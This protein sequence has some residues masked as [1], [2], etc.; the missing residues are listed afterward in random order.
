MSMIKYVDM[1]APPLLG[2][3]FRV[4]GKLDPVWINV[5]ENNVDNLITDTTLHSI[6]GGGNDSVLV[7]AP[8]GTTILVG[9]EVR[10]K[11]GEQNVS[12]WVNPNTRIIVKFCVIHGGLQPPTFGSSWMQDYAVAIKYSR[13]HGRRVSFYMMN[14]HGEHRII[15]NIY[16]VYN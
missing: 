5:S 14:Q 2:M 6:G 11:K 10:F 9:G 13:G 16:I 1:A 8:L 12:L 4:V 15:F 7:R 3:R